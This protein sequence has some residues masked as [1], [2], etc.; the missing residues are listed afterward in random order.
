MIEILLSTYN[1]EKFLPEFLKSLERQT[2]K[3]WYLMVRDDGSTDDTMNILEDFAKKH[4]KKINIVKDDL[5]NLGACKSFFTLIK[6]SIADYI[7]F[8]DQDDVWLENKI[9]ITYEYMK[10]MEKLFTSNTP[11]LI[12]T[13]LK[14]VDI[15][16][17]TISESFFSY[18]GLNP[19]Y[20]S[21]NYMILQNIITGC[22][23][24]INKTLK[25][26][27]FQLPNNAIM[28]DWWLAL[29]ASSFGQICYIPYPTILYRQHNFQDTGAI[30]YSLIDFYKKLKKKPN[31]LYSFVEKTM[32][33]A[34]EFLDIYK[35]ILPSDKKELLISYV[36][37][38]KYNKMKKLELI[39]K[40]KFFKH[41]FLRR[42]LFIMLLLSYKE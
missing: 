32:L 14:V 11:I 40:W 39:L 36:S 20:K 6:H 41:G 23:V 15:H 38:P 10:E 34:E 17:K 16:L 21:L 26:L 13:D 29:V 2:C 22:T 35:G 19:D 12:H 4:P 33:Q 28:H 7:M 37:L 18:Q 42:M 9:E 5:G 1:G 30:K 25:K 31:N 27:L 24:M 3:D 8:A